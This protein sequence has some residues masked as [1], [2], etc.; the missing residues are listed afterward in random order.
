[1]C[2]ICE[3]VGHGMI[4][5]PPGRGTI[6]RYLDN[7]LIEKYQN[8]I[9]YNWND[10]A[11]NCGGTGEQTLAKG[12]CGPCGDAFKDSQPR[13]HEIGGTYGKG[14]IVAEY[15][16]GE[17]IEITVQLTA[18]HKG[19]F[20]FRFCESSDSEISADQLSECFESNKLK[21]ESGETKWPVPDPNSSNPRHNWYKIRIQLPDVQCSN[22]VLQWKYHGGNSWGCDKENDC[23]IGKGIQ[24]EFY[25]CADISL[26]A[27]GP[28]TT[29][30]STT[31]T[32]TTTESTGVKPQKDF[33]VDLNDKYHGASGLGYK[34]KKGSYSSEDRAPDSTASVTCAPVS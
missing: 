16:S 23:G 34:V 29:T 19:Y 30:L 28:T 10:M 13:Q 7:P 15:K 17:W 14:I 26:Q 6:W 8:E 32:A 11:N 2:L 12:K 20:E 24:E 31:T 18:H 9:V 22:C 4:H 1:M 5:D 33:C 21:L 27:D 25:N 3:V